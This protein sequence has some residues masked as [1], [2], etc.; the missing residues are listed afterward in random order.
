MR[1]RYVHTVHRATPRGVTPLSVCAFSTDRR[2]FRDV[3]AELAA[4]FRR[5]SVSILAANPDAVGRYLERPY[6]KMGNAHFSISRSV[7]F[8]QVLLVQFSEVVRVP[9]AA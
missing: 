9:I 4:L 7:Q 6:D 3:A 1:S 8:C 5:V 2:Q